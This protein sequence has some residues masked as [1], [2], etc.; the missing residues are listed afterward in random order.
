NDPDA[1]IHAAARWALN[2]LMDE[3]IS[4]IDERLATGALKDGRG[5]YVNKQRQ[6]FAIIHGPAPEL[7]G[8]DKASGA[9]THRFAIGFTEVTLQQFR[10][11]KPDH[12][13]DAEFVTTEDSPVHQVSWHDA[14]RY[15][16]W[17]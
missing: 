10:A 1:G 7:L 2:M 17:L 5:W 4:R 13:V 8:A 6:T 3:E 12:K 11:F 9:S 15:C 14:A 16:N